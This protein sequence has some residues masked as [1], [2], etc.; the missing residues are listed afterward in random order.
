MDIN[1]KNNSI[2]LQIKLLILLAIIANATGMFFPCLKSMFSPYYGSIAKHIAL[3][4]NWSDLVLSGHD[5][6][7]KPHFPF[8]ITAISFKIFGINSFAYILPGFIFNLIGVYYTYRLARLWYNKETGLVAALFTI[9]ALH[10]MLSSIDVRAEAFLIGQII[11]ACYYWL[12]YDQKS[13]L[14]YLILGAFFTALAMMTKGIFTLVTITSGIIALWI[15][16]KRLHT[17]LKPKWIIA[18]I[19]AFLFIAPEIIALYQQFDS[20]PQKIIFGLTHVSGI[21]WFFWGSQFGRFFNT[22]PI[23]VNHTEDMRYLFFVYTS[24]WAYL[25][26]WPIFFIA[27][28]A[29]IKEKSAA[30]IFLLASFFITFII[31]SVTKFQIDHYTNILFPF[32]SIISARWFCNNFLNQDNINSKSVKIIYKI[33]ITLALLLFISVIILAP[34]ILSGIYRVI[35]I[36]LLILALV[37]FILRK[38]SHLAFKTIFYPTIAMCITFIFVMFVNGIEYAKYDAGYQI[39]KYLNSKS[40]I[41]VIG[42]NLDLMSLDFNSKNIYTPLSSIKDTVTPIELETL[43]QNISAIKKTSTVYL[44]TTDKDKGLIL[45]NFKNSNL[46]LVLRGTS[47]EDYM[48]GALNPQR[49]NS[50]LTNYNIIKLNSSGI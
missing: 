6:L 7:D 26:W 46:E 10:I 50:K 33:E 30:A 29:A 31:F 8:W 28:F 47:I 35:I 24:L 38:N 11:P 34:E 13:K 41:N 32:A 39:A 40:G 43:R 23:S 22:G 45:N 17:I 15:V 3:T 21:K 20:Q 14:K 5:W 1:L 2:N 19:L 44:V 49:L 27:I 16:Q 18:I 12:K 25:P 36:G 48:R 4:N 9:T 37:G 42:Y